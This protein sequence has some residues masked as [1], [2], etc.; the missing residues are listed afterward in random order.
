MSDNGSGTYVV[1]SS[2]QPVVAATPITAA[3]H[4]ALTADLATALSNRICKDGQTT[5]TANIPLGGYKLTGV[6][7]ATAR[8]DAA[9]IATIQDGTGVYVGTVGGTADAITLTPSPAITAY[10]AGQTFQFLASGANTTNVTVAISGLAAKAITKYGATALRAGDLA[11]GAMVAITYDGTRFIVMSVGTNGQ[12]TFP[13]TQNASSDANTLDDYEEG[14]W[15]PSVGGNA[16]YTIRSGTYTKIGRVVLINMVLQINVIGTGS[17]FEVSGLPFTNAGDD[18]SLSFGLY[19][20]LATAVVSLYGRINGGGNTTL[21]LF[22][23]T[24]AATGNSATSTIFGNGT[25]LSS[26]SGFYIV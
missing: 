1:N 5:P 6:G 18:A 25:S 11:S 26:V 20:S 17:T 21:T 19:S 4:N 14:T 13:A 23:S 2:G 22:G 3:V 24:A 16:T 15:T 9:T 8:T 12:I 10:V 7:A